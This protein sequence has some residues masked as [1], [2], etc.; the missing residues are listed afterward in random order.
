MDEQVQ[1]GK[2]WLEI[3]LKLMNIPADVQLGRVE[4]N[5]KQGVSCWLTIDEANLDQGQINALVGKKGDTIDAVQYLANSLLN[6][7]L[8]DTAP[9]FFTVELN[10]YRIRRQAELVA[11]AQSA[12]ARVRDTGTPEEIKYL[13]SVERRQIHSI[14]ESSD[15][16]TTESQGNE[17]E[18]R[19]IVK[20]R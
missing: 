7:G 18:R 10:G 6:I 4:E 19:L 14:L 20:L 9:C 5:D 1:R 16:L 13:S 15:D 2:Q 8:G 3:L 11:I 17:P 12:A